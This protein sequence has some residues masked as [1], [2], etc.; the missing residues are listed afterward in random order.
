MSFGARGGGLDL[1]RK[2]E[3]R[4][5]SYSVCRLE[6]VAL[7][8][9]LGPRAAFGLDLTA[10]NS[11]C[12]LEGAVEGW[13]LK[14]NFYVNVRKSMTHP[15]FKSKVGIFCRLSWIHQFWVSEKNT[16]FGKLACLIAV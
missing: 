2:Q 7:V 9:G 6:N 13:N 5:L 8:C 14:F 4:F 15:D 1:D 11:C 10:R 12:M 16:S 3:R